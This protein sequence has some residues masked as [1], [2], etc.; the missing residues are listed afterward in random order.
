[1]NSEEL[2]A[3]IWN[4]IC[5]IN[6]DIPNSLDVDLLD[7]GYISSFDML[8]I[9]SE[10]EDAFNLEFEPEVIV[11]ENFRTIERIAK[12]LSRNMK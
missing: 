8:N 10:L 4:I 7:E 2:N 3:K 9:I 6:E 12:L 11:R 5:K 1:M